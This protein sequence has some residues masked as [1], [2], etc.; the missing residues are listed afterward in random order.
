MWKF[1]LILGLSV[2][3]V[4]GNPVA[5]EVDDNDYEEEDACLTSADSADPEKECIFPTL[6]IFWVKT[7]KSVHCTI[8]LHAKRIFHLC[9]QNSFNKALI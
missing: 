8:I 9:F 4:T 1:C 7:I 6:A 3:L 5:I 2:W